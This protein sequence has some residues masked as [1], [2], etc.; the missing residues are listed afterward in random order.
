MT[1]HVHTAHRTMSTHGSAA[2][3]AVTASG[4]ATHSTSGPTAHSA[5]GAAATSV[6][7]AVTTRTRHNS[8]LHFSIFDGFIISQIREKTNT[9]SVFFI[10]EM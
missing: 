4:T 2:H 10:N 3:A 5:S 9:D 1:A 6:T 7:A 8:Y